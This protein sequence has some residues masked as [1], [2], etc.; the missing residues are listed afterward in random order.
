MAALLNNNTVEMAE[1]Q[2][3]DAHNVK[4]LE[5]SSIHRNGHR[6]EVR[7]LGFSSDSNSILSASG[8]QVKLWSRSDTVLS[9][10]PSLPLCHPQ[11]G[12]FLGS[13]IF[14]PFADM[15]G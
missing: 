7:T 1:V 3:V 4:C 6:S 2:L 12:S 8:E 11:F 14:N 10:T 9:S 13:L 15:C 5:T